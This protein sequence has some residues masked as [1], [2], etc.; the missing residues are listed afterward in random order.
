M[1]P[2]SWRSALALGAVA[3][4]A[5]ALGCGR[6][7]SG[8]YSAADLQAE[9]RR[10]GKALVRYLAQPG[11]DGGVCNPDRSGPA[12]ERVDDAVVVRL[13]GALAQG[14]VPPDAGAACLVAAW[15]APPDVAARVLI[16]S[17]EAAP[18]MLGQPAGEA[19]LVALAERPPGLATPRE[20]ALALVHA[21]RQAGGQGAYAAALARDLELEAGAYEGEPVT[22][23]RI[24]QVRDEAVL[25]AM[26]ARLPAEGLRS[27]AAARL[28]RVRAERSP[29]ALVRDDPDAAVRE[30]L[31]TGALAV[32]VVAHPVLHA[33]YVP[34]EDAAQAVLLEQ[35]LQAG[36]RRLIAAYADGT[37]LPDPRVDLRTSLR[38]LL[39][40]LEEPITLCA[41]ASERWD[42]T[43]CV[44]LDDVI[45]SHLALTI[46]GEGALV[47]KEELPLEA[48][49]ALGRDGDVLRP[50]VLVGGVEVQD[51]DLPLFFLP[52]EPARFVGGGPRGAG[53]L[54]L[55]D[56]Y[57]ASASRLIFGVRVPTLDRRMAA[58]VPQH[59]EGFAVISQGA[60]GAVGSTGA[61]G[62]PGTPGSIGMPA[63]CPS[64]PGQNGG[65]GGPGG[66]GGKGGSG[67]P[68]G[69]GGFLKVS[70]HC[71]RCELLEPML[72]RRLRSEGGPGGPGGAGGP[73][74]PGGRG[75]MGGSGTSC[76]TYDSY[77]KTSRSSY[78]SGGAKGADGARGPNGASGEPGPPGP[79]GRVAIEIMEE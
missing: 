71:E 53:P 31:A 10:P 6:G 45:V 4:L 57:E 16:H 38:L 14:D 35:D 32:D 76:S 2:R 69:P 68:G 33:R 67:G 60:R 1:S 21:L 70:L 48:V 47:M 29:F 18:A 46:D 23:A 55:V 8:P 25:D 40:G 64:S 75:G 56:V 65:S 51:L 13:L 7:A 26:A 63:S 50:R 19:L 43:P 58:L 44:S 12:V 5:L 41:G 11:A 27:A 79:P 17:L 52:V 9:S 39:S 37:R 54:V 59:D 73:G 3:L 49:V 36:T 72:R 30:V 34:R 42:P 24:R 22:E 62:A 74:G 77:T 61:A 20:P 15:S 78:L 66:Q 28:V